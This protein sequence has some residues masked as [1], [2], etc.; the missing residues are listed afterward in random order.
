MPE[1][2]S[3]TVQVR[4]SPSLLRVL[5]KLSEKT[6]LD[7]SNVIRLAVTKLAEAEGIKPATRP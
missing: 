5:R 3:K 4:F 2:T 6:G 1:S 7:H